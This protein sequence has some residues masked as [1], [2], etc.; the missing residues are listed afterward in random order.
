MHLL[1]I[2]RIQVTVELI[3]VTICNYIAIYRH[4]FLF[5]TGGMR[6]HAPPT[7]IISLLMENALRIGALRGKQRRIFDS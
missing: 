4:N 3:F 6:R 1:R 7:L 5:R 2:I